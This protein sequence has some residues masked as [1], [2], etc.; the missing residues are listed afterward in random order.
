[1]LTN[2]AKPKIKTIETEAEKR[3]RKRVTVAQEILT[4]E[5]SYVENLRLIVQVWLAPMIEANKSAKVPVSFSI[6]LA[7]FDTIRNDS[8]LK[9]CR[10][11]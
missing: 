2:T 4:T 7:L 3:A 9:V 10:D 11:Q 6:S 8:Y 1:M 5:Q